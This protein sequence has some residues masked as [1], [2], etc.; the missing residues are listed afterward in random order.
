M[1]KI[2]IYSALGTVLILYGT[3]A[4]SNAYAED[5]TSDTNVSQSYTEERCLVNQEVLDTLLKEGTISEK[6][7]D[8]IQA[9]RELGP[10]ERRRMNGVGR[11]MS[12]EERNLYRE[13]M[14]RARKSKILEILK[15]KGFEVS[16]DE[17]DEVR[18]IMKEIGGVQERAGRKGE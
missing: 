3:Y 2:V 6:Q 8:I 4:V 1:R 18:D 10:N 16:E 13:E 11:Q 15:E 17:L 14:Q 7:M 9:I 12:V 5:T